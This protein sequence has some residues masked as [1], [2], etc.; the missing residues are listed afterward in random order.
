MLALPV[1][2]F[3]LLFGRE[4]FVESRQARKSAGPRVVLGTPA[5]AW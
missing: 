4:W 3:G 2:V 1:P 5:D